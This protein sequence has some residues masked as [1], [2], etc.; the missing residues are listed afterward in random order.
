MYNEYTNIYKHPK[1]TD[2]WL[3]IQIV[4]D[5]VEGPNRQQLLHIAS[6]FEKGQDWAER[7]LR[8]AEYYFEWDE[9]GLKFVLEAGGAYPGALLI[10][11]YA[12][13]HYPVDQIE[14]EMNLDPLKDQL[15]S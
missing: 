1:L 3:V 2:V 15:L 14:M 7:Y 11:P 8:E 12:V 13:D 5:E 6:T 9:E 10:R 4:S